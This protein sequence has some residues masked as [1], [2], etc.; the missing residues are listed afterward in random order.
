M[1][2]YSSLY[3][4]LLAN[5]KIPE[6]QSENTG[7][8]QWTGRT[9]GKRWPYG[10]INIIVNGKHTTKA[11]HRLMEELLIGRKI[12][13]EEETID[14]LCFNTLCINPDHWDLTDRV[15]NSIRGRVDR[16]GT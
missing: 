15:E 7:C 16:A 14:H 2:R 9:D 1:P 11:P 6:G 8:W 12:D 3:E 13:P 5:S 4:R 10:R